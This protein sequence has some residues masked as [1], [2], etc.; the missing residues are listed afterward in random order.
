MDAGI[1]TVGERH[2]NSA[3]TDTCQTTTCNGYTY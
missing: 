1:C 3:V 2:N